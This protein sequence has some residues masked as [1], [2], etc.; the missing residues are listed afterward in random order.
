MRARARWLSL[1][2]RGEGALEQT[3]EEVGGVDVPLGRMSRTEDVA[4]PVAWLLSP[5]ARG[6]TGHAL[7]QNGG[8]FMA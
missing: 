8:P 6:V 3:A 5:D 2:V 7:D 4:G 1:L